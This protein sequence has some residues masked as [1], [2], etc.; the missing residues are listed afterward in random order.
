[1]FLLNNVSFESNTSMEDLCIAREQSLRIRDVV[2]NQGFA[3]HYRDIL[4]TVSFGMW[5]N[6]YSKGEGP[7]DFF[8]Y[9]EAKIF[10]YDFLEGHTSDNI[11]VSCIEDRIG[12]NFEPSDGF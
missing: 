4:N 1:M 2:K 5:E 12:R 9:V 10:E 3:M 7:I 8:S 6:Q 11:T